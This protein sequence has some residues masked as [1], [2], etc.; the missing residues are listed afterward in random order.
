MRRLGVN[1]LHANEMGVGGLAKI[2]DVLA[3]QKRFRF[4]FAA[5]TRTWMRSQTRRRFQ[6][7]LLDVLQSRS[8][9]SLG[10]AAGS[11][12]TRCG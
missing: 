3:L 6:I 12:W 5:S 9:R 7:G 2:E 4:G 11:G 10:V 1:A 8:V